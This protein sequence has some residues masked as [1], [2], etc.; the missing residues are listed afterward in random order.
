MDRYVPIF[1][2]IV[3]SS[4]WV[5]PDYVVKVFLT[6]LAKKDPDEVV[7]G[8]AFNIACWAKKSE[9][10]VLDALEILASPDRKRLEPQPF[11]GR[12][13][14]KVEGGWKLLNGEK[15]QLEMIQLNRRARKTELQREY[16]AAAKEVVAPVPGNV[17]E[18]KP[19][20]VAVFAKP[21]LLDVKACMM[22]RGMGK[23]EAHDLAEK[24]MA[25]YES[26][27][28]RVGKAPMKSWSAAV[29]T[30]MKNN[31]NR[32]TI[33][34]NVGVSV[35]RTDCNEGT[36]NEGKASQYAGIGRVVEL[37]KV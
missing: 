34:N 20:R 4:L 35:R 9:R 31:D 19:S 27:G 5:E 29:T 18:E 32:S 26:N 28:W 11:E 23:P 12:R 13:I 16:R 8:S 7:R 22:D 30:W 15:Y 6:M 36:A 21:V 10:E 37:P 1:S 33:K 17:A 3:D 2:K 24:F 25:H 14:E